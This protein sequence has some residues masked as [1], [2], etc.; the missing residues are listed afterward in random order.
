[1][2]PACLYL[3]PPMYQSFQSRHM[4]AYANELDHFVDIVL[5]RVETSVTEEMTKGVGK[6]GEACKESVK[7]GLPVKIKWT[8]EEIPKNYVMNV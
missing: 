2:S 7:T 6:I 4:Q 5:G 3:R 1:L 8:K